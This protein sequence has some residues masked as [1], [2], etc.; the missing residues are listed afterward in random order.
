MLSNG[1]LSGESGKIDM[2]FLGKKRRWPIFH[3]CGR[4]ISKGVGYWNRTNRF[5]IVS[6]CAQPN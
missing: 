1:L 6:F 2:A 3:I 4:G 5:G